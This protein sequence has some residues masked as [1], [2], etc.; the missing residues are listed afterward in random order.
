MLFIYLNKGHPLACLQDSLP[1]N[2][3][4]PFTHAAP[5]LMVDWE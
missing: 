3:K 5:T 1:N 2:P 4:A